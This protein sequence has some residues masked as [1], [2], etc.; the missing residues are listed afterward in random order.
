MIA[1]YLLVAVWCFL[2]VRGTAQTTATLSGSVVDATTDTP[3]S[4]A[5]VQVFVAD[6]S[7]GST[8]DAFGTFRITDLPTGIHRVRASFIGYIP[9]EIAEVWVRS[10][11]EESVELSM[12]RSANELGE[13]EV[14]ALA[15]QRLDAIGTHVLTVEKSLRYP[16]T[17]FDPARLAMSFA[18][19]ASSM[20]RQPFQR[21]WKWTGRQ[22]MAV[23]RAEIV[24]QTT[25]GM[26]NQK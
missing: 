18:G 12:Q 22:C 3:L 20:T 13:A 7:V 5:Y 26:Q 9:V 4:G 6:S 1:R 19:V 2:V 15:P 11:K 21:A 8:S 25:P 10:G 16:A 14:R 24:N 23:G 17:F